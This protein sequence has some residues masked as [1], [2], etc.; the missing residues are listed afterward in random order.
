MSSSDA[1]F[2]C[3]PLLLLP[4]LFLTICAHHLFF[5]HDAQAVLNQAPLL[6]RHRTETVAAA[7]AN[8]ERLIP[9]LRCV[10]EVGHSRFATMSSRVRRDFSEFVSPRWTEQK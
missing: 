10:E 7:L 5:F 6:L 1:V 8:T 4:L 2:S 9:G 3:V